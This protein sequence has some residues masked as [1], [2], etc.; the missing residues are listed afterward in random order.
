MPIFIGWLAGVIVGAVLAAAGMFA[1][2]I[3]IPPILG[4]FSLLTALPLVAVLALVVLAYVLAYV[5]A[6][7]SVAPLLPAVTFPLAAPVAVP[8]VVSVPL[9]AVAGELTARGFSIGLTAVLNALVVLLVPIHGVM[10]SVWVFV[11]VSLAIVTPVARSG[12]YHGFLGWTAWLLP[13]SYVATAVGLLLFVINAPVAFAFGGLGAFRIDWSTGVIESSGGFVGIPAITGSFTGGF[14]LGNFTF[15]TAV[16]L[17]DGFLFQ[18][19]SS[20]ETGH[21]LNTAALGGI[22]LWVN[23][24]DENVAP[25]ARRNL[26]YGELTAE[27]HSEGLPAPPAGARRDFFVRS[28]G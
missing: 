23:A 16:A 18:G 13:V 20:H 22:V 12:I 3:A 21:T 10:P 17:Q 14:S 26:A 28:W 11:V 19:L 7:R 25:F 6:T 4:P 9:P 27:S 5:L 15:L 2:S 24:V 1:L 8:G